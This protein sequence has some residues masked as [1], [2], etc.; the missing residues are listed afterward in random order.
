MTSADFADFYAAVHEGRLPFPWQ[1][2]LA[3]QV[4]NGGE[5]P[6][7]IAIPTACG[8]TSVI[9]VAVFSLAAQAGLPPCQ[10]TAA[11]RIFFVI[12]RRLVVDD[13][14]RHARELAEAIEESESEAV[15][16]VREGLRRFGGAKALEVATLRGGMYRSD[17]WAHAPNQPVVCVSTV[18]QVGSR[19]LFRG[20]GVSD[21]RRPVHAALVG[22]DSLIIVD[23]AHLSQP[24]LDTLDWVRT[25]QGDGW[26]ERRVASGLRLVKMSATG[27]DDKAAFQ[28]K[29]EDYNSALKDRLEAQKI[30]ELREAANLERAA[31]DD[32]VGLADEGG[33]VVG[34]ILNTIAS[35]RATFELLR[36]AGEEAL[37]LTGRVRPYD[38]DRLVDGYL[39]RIKAGRVRR[40]SERLFVV[41]TQTVEVG[42]D[43]DFDG[44]VTEAAPLD[45]L[46]QRFGRL[47]RLG[48]KKSSR[49]VILRPK[50]AKAGEWIYGE[51]LESAWKWLNAH[52]E[53][54]DG[55][56]VIDFGVRR[57]KEGF[58]RH[59]EASLNTAS[60]G[61][62]L[63]LPAY[64]DAWVQTNP[65]PAAEP[66]VAPFLHG[67]KAL[68][69]ADVQVVWRA[70]LV[71]RVQDWA[72]IIAL[73]P[74]V[75]SEA[76]PLPIGL[77]RRWLS[78]ELGEVTDI[79]GASA[80]PGGDERERTVREFLI[81]RGPEEPL[82]GLSA[83]RPGDTIVVRSEEGGGD[84][85]GW[86]PES[87]R[88]EDIGDLCANERARAGFGRFRVRLH[89]W[90]LYPRADQVEQR[91]ELTELLRAAAEHDEEALEGL[92]ERIRVAAPE[93]E[94]W[95]RQQYGDGWVIGVS[96]FPKRTGERR[97]TAA[98]PEETDEDESSSLT[99]N[100]TLR[101]HTEGVVRKADGFAQKCG[102]GDEAA[103]AVEI[104]ARLHDE[105]KR[106]DRF[107]MLLDPARDPTLE[108]LAKGK[109]DP[110]QFRRRRQFAGY[111][112]GARHEFAS[113][114]IAENFGDWPEGCD[115][116]LALHLIGTHHGRGRPLPP[117]WI[118]DPNH[119]IR[120]NGGAISMQCV[121]DRAKFGSGW[122]DRFWA[123]TRK[124]GWWGL[125]YL[126]AI[127]RLG[128]CARSREEQ[129][130]GE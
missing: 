127:L 31:A 60:E 129:E 76:M 124:Y 1:E 8:K 103:R 39:E 96:R 7:A 65:A 102:L 14:S 44:L 110:S 74:P 32:A 93:G 15:V 20:Y 88:V 83:L 26:T 35:A 85:Y 51:A 42:A 16:R 36:E 37:L 5:W 30:G 92:N 121:L 130:E 47:D 21:S 128:D 48:E 33:G 82:L 61:G 38:R 67:K 100:V 50:R 58:E 4:L 13:V 45:S 12:D 53:L 91:Q 68:Q 111:P 2:R 28:L 24:F 89:P 112:K 106:D 117:V 113:V 104:A 108:P 75:S 25:Y 114:V 54:V 64:V 41:A 99:G 18:D 80:E 70:D 123:L 27:R 10:R 46:R 19:L 40:E 22:N 72:E 94:D 118:D 87:G 52:A 90:V 71:G 126:E 9:D 86:H 59:G 116:D 63:M 119:Q 6:A 66:D 17:A 29:Q 77:A 11:L 122:V 105:G 95:K 78:G 49:A 56:P 120:V 69:A 57:M 23:E 98:E 81:W 97:K 73:A 34:V 55:R 84:E 109:A 125:A 43:L 3:N 79:E 62:P 101:K 107:Q 115:R